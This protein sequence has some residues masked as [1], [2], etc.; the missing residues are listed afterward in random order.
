M[1]TYFPVIVM[2]VIFFAAIGTVALI[3][4]TVKILREYERAV[5]FTLAGSTAYAAPGSSCWCRSSKKWCG[6]I[7]VSK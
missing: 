2:A 6:S 7:C 4:G 3:G 1:T 5:V